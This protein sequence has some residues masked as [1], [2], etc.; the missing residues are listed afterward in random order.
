[1]LHNRSATLLRRTTTP[2]LILSCQRR[3]SRRQEI[4][5]TALKAR[6]NWLLA[7]VTLSPEND[8][9]DTRAGIDAALSWALEIAG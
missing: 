9:P 1:M 4:D 7:D 5:V 2:T 8:H 6:L 3:R